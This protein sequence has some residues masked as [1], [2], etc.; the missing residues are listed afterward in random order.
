MGFELSNIESFLENFKGCQFLELY[1]DK[2]VPAIFSPTVIGMMSKHWRS[3]EILIS[4]KV[5]GP[6]PNN[7]LILNLKLGVLIKLKV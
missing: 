7:Y 2:N 6:K 5:Y 1:Q 3:T 4:L